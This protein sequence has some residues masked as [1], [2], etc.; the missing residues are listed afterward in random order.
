VRDVTAGNFGLLIAYLLPGFIAL[1]GVSGLSSTV[2][3][4]LTTG[5]AVPTVGGF[6]YVTLASLGAGLIISTARW[7]LVDTLHHWT[8][9]RPPTWNFARLPRKL[10][11][12]QLLVESHY[13]HYQFHANALVAV[14]FDYAVWRTS[15]RASDVDLVD[16]AFLLVGL[17]LLVG[18]RD[19]LRKYYRRAE[20][21]L[22]E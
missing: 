12:F 21:L 7:L 4:W 14:A 9:I 2:S 16:L 15:G 1:W 11:A 8:G 6:L 3:G 20:A 18:S 22:G 17:L 5:P 10:D 13:R 19:T